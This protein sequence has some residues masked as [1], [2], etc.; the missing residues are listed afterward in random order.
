MK[1]KQQSMKMKQ[2]SMKMKQ[3]SIDEAAKYEDV[4]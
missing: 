2:Q 3:Q 4:T 1:M